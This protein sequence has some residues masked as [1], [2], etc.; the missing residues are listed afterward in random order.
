MAIERV[1]RRVAL[2]GHAVPEMD[3]R[4]RFDRG[5]RNFFGLYSQLADR[6]ALFDNSQSEGP[7]LG[8]FCERHH[9]PTVV[10]LSLWREYWERN[11]GTS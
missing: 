4:R 6:W 3:I 5:L 1:K 11:H 10:E 8:A 9:E 7:Q 2:G